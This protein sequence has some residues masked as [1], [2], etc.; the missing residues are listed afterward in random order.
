MYVLVYS[1]RVCA[2]EICTLTASDYRH[3]CELLCTAT[4]ESVV[5][6]RFGSKALRIFR[7]L[8][9]KKALEQKQVVEMAML[10]SRDARSMLYTLVTESFVTQLEIPRTPDYA[11]SRTFYLYSVNL[12]NVARVVLERC[13]KV[14]GTCTNVCLKWPPCL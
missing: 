3:A 13:Y 12:P 5:R 2:A 4:I 8:I 6:E 11:P 9:L 7:L 14:C 1:S 10:S